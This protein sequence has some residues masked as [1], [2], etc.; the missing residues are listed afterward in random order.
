M[1]FWAAS[2]GIQALAGTNSENVGVSPALICVTT[3]GPMADVHCP[4]LGSV[5]QRLRTRGIVAAPVSA[6]TV[7]VPPDPTLAVATAKTPL[8]TTCGMLTMPSPLSVPE[9][10]ITSGAGTVEAESSSVLTP[11]IGA[12]G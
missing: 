1:R 3:V 5:R 12:T 10:A 6:D 4:V 9:R 2:N 8:P 7:M 11:M